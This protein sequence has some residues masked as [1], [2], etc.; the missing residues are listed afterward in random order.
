M[1]GMAGFV[2]DTNLNVEYVK[3]EG[4]WNGPAIT[5]VVIAIMSSISL[6]CAT[7][8]WN[9][10]MRIIAS[11]CLIGFAASVAFSSPVSYAR[12]LSSINAQQEGVGSHNQ[13]VELLRKT[14]A[15]TKALRVQESKKGG[16]GRNCKALMKREQELLDQII[17]AGVSKGKSL[18][19]TVAMT[20]P[21]AAVIALTCLMNGLFV[22]GFNGLVQLS[23]TTKTQTPQKKT[24]RRRKR[25]STNKQKVTQNKKPTK[26]SVPR[27]VARLA[28]GPVANGV[29]SVP[30]A[31]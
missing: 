2:A 25:R 31:S 12:I 18:D 30:R 10:K 13:K 6:A 1:A 26:V 20:V 14:H 9:M 8:A 21:L 4:D 28:T 17:T 27:N 29:I 23:T 22:F 3:G 19:D 24:T 11:M 15:E 16:C 5:V 7:V